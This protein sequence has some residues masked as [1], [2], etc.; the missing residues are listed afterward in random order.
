[1][2]RGPP[3]YHLDG[4]DQ[5]AE[6]R[7]AIETPADDVDR[8]S[9]PEPGGRTAAPVAAAI[10]APIAS[11]KPPPRA[12]RAAW[13]GMSRTAHALGMHRFLLPDA[14][15]V[16]GCLSRP[17]RVA[18]CAARHRRADPGLS[19]AASKR[20]ARASYR[21]YYRTCVDLAWA[22]DLDPE[23][24]R[25]RH[26]I[27]QLEI[28]REVQ[29]EHGG[30]LLCLAHFGNWDM[31]ATMAL[32][33]GL[34]LTTVMR[35]FHPEVL[36][37]TVIWARERRGLEVFTPDDAAKGLLAALRRGRLLALLV[38][39]PEG[40]PTIQ[41]RFRRGPVLFSAAPAV[42]ARRSGCPIIP[43]A[44]F[45]DGDHY[46]IVVDRAIDPRGRIEAM[47]QEL[48]DRLDALMAHAPAQWYPFNQVWTDEAP[49]PGSAGRGV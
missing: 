39:L 48:A 20:R 32:S 3:G 19:V 45:R 24:V 34:A 37:E 5:G 15:A 7:T 29:R 28:I 9:G 1:L 12:V 42:L 2:A 31:A 47:T 14:A 18:A 44:C 23:E 6:R 25:R 30:G 33:H 21:E 38:D 27:D 13:T 17:G 26:P 40:G 36:N 11:A 43:V 49:R 10:G 8:I 4:A 35:E 46:R 22:H 41:V 16:I